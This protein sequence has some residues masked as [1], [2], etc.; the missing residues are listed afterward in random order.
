MQK[1]K[2]LLPVN[3]KIKKKKGGKGRDEAEGM[4]SSPSPS[5]PRRED[6]SSS[7]WKYLVTQFGKLFRKQEIVS[8]GVEGRRGSGKMIDR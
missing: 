1:K 3:G 7:P 6:R 5:L 8:P 4:K 2:S